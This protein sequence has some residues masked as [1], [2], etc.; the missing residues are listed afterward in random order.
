MYYALYETATGSLVSTGTVIADPV[1]A[2]LTAKE[3]PSGYPEA[4]SWNEVTKDFDIIIP[5]V[6]NV[7]R[8]AFLMSFTAD[9]RKQIRKDAKTNE[10]IDDFLFMTENANIINLL[11]DT[12][13]DGLN[14][15]VA[16]GIITANRKVEIE[17]GV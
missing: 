11:A 14:Y 1:P 7:S 8:L 10:A 17:S 16:L 3:Y 2:H 5:E 4:M 6:R 12:T 13:Q 9:E 15:M